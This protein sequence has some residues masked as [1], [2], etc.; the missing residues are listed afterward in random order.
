MS[1]LREALVA[2]SISTALLVSSSANAF[3]QSVSVS[4]TTKNVPITRSVSISVSWNPTVVSPVP[5]TVS[6]SQGEFKI[7]L[8]TV[9]TNPRTLQ[10]T[11][12]TQSQLAVLSFPEVVQVPI[13]VIA[14]ANK[15]GFAG[16]TYRR[17]FDD[18]SGQSSFA[19]VILPISGNL[20]AG[21]DVSRLA[22]HFEDKSLQKV[23]KLGAAP[24]AQADISFTGSGLLRAVWEL[25][26]PESTSG[27]AVFLPIQTVRRFLSIQ[28]RATLTS[29]A[30]PANAVGTHRVRLRIQD[31]PTG[32]DT[33][34]V[35]Y[36]VAD[37][38]TA[39]AAPAPV[40]LGV[41]GPAP[42]AALEADTRF[43][44]QGLPG[45]QAY[46]LEL[47]ASRP[48][49]QQV[50]ARSTAPEGLLSQP[51]SPLGASERPVSGMMVRGTAT[52][53]SALAR[54]RLTR[55][56]SYYWRIRAIGEGGALIGESALRELRIP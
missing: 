45:V 54:S 18:G 28:G 17:A 42:S 16:I 1:H 55:G 47:Y 5:V 33:P 25:A 56:R 30:L 24:T 2:L 23:V 34:E 52:G 8:Q 48:G 29:P 38:S 7:G 49:G 27:A 50:A 37:D 41:T 36:Y 13:D 19:T 44:W 46:R 6:S 9:K 15:Q 3:V 4:P 51:A 11:V 39:D 10:R 12:T 31:P 35:Q 43:V 21:F 32:F 53:L 14:Q 22:L 26:T 40:S 20:G